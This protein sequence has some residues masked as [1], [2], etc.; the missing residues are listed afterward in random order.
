MEN[1][2]ERV[3]NFGE[4]CP[5]KKHLLLQVCKANFEARDGAVE[6]SAGCRAHNISRFLVRVPPRSTKPSIPPR[7]LH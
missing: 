4:A 2:I 7:S 6:R 3:E 1:S 5:Y